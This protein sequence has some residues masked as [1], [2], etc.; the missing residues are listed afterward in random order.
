LEVTHN[1]VKLELILDITPADKNRGVSDKERS[2]P[3]KSESASP[4]FKS[5]LNKLICNSAFFFSAV[6]CLLTYYLFKF[7]A[8]S[9]KFD[10]AQQIIMLLNS[11]LGRRK[12]QNQSHSNLS[13]SRVKI[14]RS[15]AAS[16][17]SL[18]LCRRYTSGK[19]INSF[20]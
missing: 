3:S 14:K 1:R 10:T 11:A 6:L 17:F 8:I 19:H 4:R 2:Y 12:Q 18:E 15:R 5:S 20:R 7:W 13:L 9:L 16:L